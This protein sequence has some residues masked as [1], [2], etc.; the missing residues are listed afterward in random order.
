VPNVPLTDK[1]V[2]SAGFGNLVNLA[3]S[4]G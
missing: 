1:A 3:R 2:K 4:N